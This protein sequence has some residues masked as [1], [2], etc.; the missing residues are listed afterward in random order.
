MSIHVHTF[1]TKYKKKLLLISVKKIK[2]GTTVFLYIT[3][4]NFYGNIS[5]YSERSFEVQQ[6][7]LI[8]LLK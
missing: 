2:K 6:N 5:C 8:S 7:F 1:F 3:G 4:S